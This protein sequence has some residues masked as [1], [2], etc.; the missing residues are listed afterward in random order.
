MVERELPTNLVWIHAAVSEK[1][2][3]TERRMDNRRLCHDSTSSSADKVK[4]S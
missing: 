1:P 3:F 2:E 4:Q